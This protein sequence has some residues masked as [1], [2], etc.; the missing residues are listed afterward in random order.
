MLRER[1]SWKVV[2]ILT[3]EQRVPTMSDI[4]LL[5]QNLAGEH[6]GIAAYDAALGSG[7]LDEATANVARAFQSDHKCHRD[8]LTDEIVARNGTPV[9]PLAADAY[10]KSY[11]PLT[12][13]A[14]ILA[15]A[16]ELEAGATRGSI[17]SV[18]DFEDRKLALLAAQIGGVEA[19]HWASLLA[20]SGAHPVPSPLIELDGMAHAGYAADATTS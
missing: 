1:R 11:P 18:A 6:L 14:D 9:S 12:T 19:Q 13:A 4:D 7:L 10:A 2:S 16:I 5:E 3:A 8:L 17:A 15:F 20:A